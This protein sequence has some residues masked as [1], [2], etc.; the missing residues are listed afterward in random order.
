MKKRFYLTTILLLLSFNACSDTPKQNYE[1]SEDKVKLNI[2]FIDKKW[3]GVTVPK[4]EVCSDHNKEGGESPALSINNLPTQT[5][6]MILSFSDETFKGMRNGGHGTIGYEVK[7]GSSS[8]TIPSVKGETF[9]LPTGFKLVREHQGVQFGK[10]EGAYL[11][12]CSG[13][14]GNQYTL[15]VKAIHK[16]TDGKG[17]YILLGDANISL[18]RY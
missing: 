7:E 15:D 16:P 9:T 2:T 14:S 11:P 18:G 4:E 10:Q 6:Y 13:G 17:K 12:P 8:L 1:V 5:N 3:D